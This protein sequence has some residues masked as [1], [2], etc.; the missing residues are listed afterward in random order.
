MPSY[1]QKIFGLICLII[2]IILIVQGH[3]MANSVG[4]QVN[5]LINGAPSN[6]V[7]YYYVGGIALAI[8]GVSQL[9]WPSKSK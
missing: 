6:K 9:V 1:T 8:F 5:Q 7:T 2:G 3:G 4:S